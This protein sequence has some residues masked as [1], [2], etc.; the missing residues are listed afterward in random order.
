MKELKYNVEEYHR[1]EWQPLMVKDADGKKVQ[2]HVMITEE[3]AEIMNKT[4]KDR[5]LR[6]ILADGQ[7]SDSTTSDSQAPGLGAGD[8]N[9]GGGIDDAGGTSPDHK[10]DEF[11][12]MDKPALKEAYKKAFNKNPFHGWNEDQLKEK[13]RANTEA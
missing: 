8:D 12:A 2:K 1:G 10:A 4:S 5:K 13:L 11:D 3:Q 7:E 6:Y 9:T